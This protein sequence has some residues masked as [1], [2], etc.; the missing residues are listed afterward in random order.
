MRSDLAHEARQQVTEFGAIAIAGAHEPLD[1]DRH[2]KRGAR[3]V[4]VPQRELAVLRPADDPPQDVLE[5]IQHL[6]TTL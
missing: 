5:A 3:V 4:R 6:Q 1:R 2:G